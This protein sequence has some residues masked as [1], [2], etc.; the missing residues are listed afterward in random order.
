VEE[1]ARVE[2]EIDRLRPKFLRP[3][4]LGRQEINEIR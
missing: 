3:E 1:E 4:K 2:R